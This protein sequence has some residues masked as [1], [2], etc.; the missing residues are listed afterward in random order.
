ML[1]Q[2]LKVYTKDIILSYTNVCRF[3]T[4]I[5]EVIQTATNAGEVEQSIRDTSATFVI[6]GVPE[7]IGIKANGAEDIAG[8]A[9]TSFLHSF[10]NIQSNDFL[11]GTEAML[12]G[13][14]N[15]A[16]VAE[17]IES[18]AAQ[19]EERTEAFRHSV[20]M[21]DDELEAIVKMIT[22]Y[23]KIPVII[24][25]G[26]N[27]AYGCIKGAAKG[28]HKEGVLPLAQLNV[29][30]LDA[31]TGYKPLEGRHSSNALRYADEDGYLQKYCVVGL[32]ENELPQNTWL[33]IANNPFFDF[34]T[35]EDIF[36]HG[37]Q[38]FV[39]A[40]HHAISFTG[41][42]LCGIEIGLSNVLN[43]SRSAV[44][45]SLLHARQFVHLTAVHSQPAYLHIAE[46]FNRN[47]KSYD[48]DAAGKIISYLVSD[49]IKIIG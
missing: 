18:N 35:Y 49:F 10:L 30:S 19:K 42:S 5:G 28:W 4:K 6:V 33:D 48:A 29:I 43:A 27:N 1:S 32:H 25:G 37:K 26:S 36:L 40:V 23:R 20:S 11:E 46:P 44:G 3:E 8:S 24:S 47:I 12:L 2:R 7:D 34:I 17:V 39:D 15:F 38:S 9:W 22:S 31:Q 14:L 41:D 13:H 21:V 45:I 16:G